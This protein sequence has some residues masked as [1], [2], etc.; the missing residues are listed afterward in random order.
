MKIDDLEL[1]YVYSHKLFI[2]MKNGLR[3]KDM[4]L[5][6]KK[7]LQHSMKLCKKWIK[8]WTKIFKT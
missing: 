6:I 8:F 7:N 3:N 1:L 4:D 5:E 2:D